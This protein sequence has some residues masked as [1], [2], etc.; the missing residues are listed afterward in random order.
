R[1]KLANLL[2][3][4]L[5]VGVVGEDRAILEAD[6][7]ERIDRD[8][9]DVVRSLL[10]GEVEEVVDQPRRRDDR[11]ASVEGEPVLPVHVGATARLVALLDDGHV[12]PLGLQP[13]GCGQTPKP[14]SD[15]D[16]AHTSPNAREPSLVRN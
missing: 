1:A 12:V 3:Q 15:D 9:L 7:I 5:A 4:V 11:G 14:T 13:D 6:P 16:D 2:E 8:D 10:A